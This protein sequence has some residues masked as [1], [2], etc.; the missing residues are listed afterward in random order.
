MVLT[1]FDLKALKQPPQCPDLNPPMATFGMNLNANR[2]NGY[3]SRDLVKMIIGAF[4]KQFFSK[5]RQI[6]NDCFNP[7]QEKFRCIDTNQT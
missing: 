2:S 1:T 6:Q 7:A 4:I 5:V 3:R